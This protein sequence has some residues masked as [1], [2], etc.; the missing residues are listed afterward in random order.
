MTNGTASVRLEY[1]RKGE[2]R[3]SSLPVVLPWVVL[4][5]GLHLP[6]ALTR[7]PEV[8]LAFLVVPELQ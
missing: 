6:L 4:Q 7:L 8:I 2:A 5:Q 3:V 1:W